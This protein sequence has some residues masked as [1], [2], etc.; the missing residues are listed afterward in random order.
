MAMA[1]VAMR[2]PRTEKM[3]R[4]ANRLVIL[5]VRIRRSRP[6]VRAKKAMTH[7]WMALNHQGVPHPWPEATEIRS[8]ERRVGKGC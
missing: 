4:G 1:L 5:N 7:Q 8:E 2:R 3:A 6:V